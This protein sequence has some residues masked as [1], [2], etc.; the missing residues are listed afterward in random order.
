MN[1]KIFNRFRRYL[2]KILMFWPQLKLAVV[3]RN[4]R[5]EFSRL[6]PKFEEIYGKITGQ[7]N[8]ASVFITPFWAE[9][10][11]KYEKILLPAPPFSFLRNKLISYTMVFTKGGKFLRSRVDFLEKIFPQNELKIILEEDYVGSP[12][13]VSAKYLASHNSVYHFYHIGKFLDGTKADLNDI[14]LIVEW[15]GGYG[16]MAKL[17]W[18]LKQG[19]LT[20]VLIDTALFSCLQWLYL[21]VALG[22]E[23]IKIISSPQERIENGKINILPLNFLNNY[24]EQGTLTQ[25]SL[26]NLNADLFVSTWALSESSEFTQKYVEKNNFFNA[27]R[28][29]LAYQKSNKFLPD[30][31][32]IGELAEKRGAV[33]EEIIDMKGNY[34]VFQ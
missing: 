15:G 30:A 9:L 29:L 4:Q 10:N 7:N 13:L 17:F 2:F 22:E 12:T 8:N 33:V 5:K 28:L 27:P 32:K 25:A 6:V 1:K 16:N 3:K 21:S 11:K 31:G 20:Y 26:N 19:D 23:K 34:Y 24:S 18:R 14:K